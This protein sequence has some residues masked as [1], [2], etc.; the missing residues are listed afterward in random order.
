MKKYLFAL[1]ILVFFSNCNDDNKRNVNPF[2]PDYSFSYPINLTLPSFQPLQSNVNAMYI[3]TQ[4]VGVKGI[5]V[6][7]VSAT[8]YRAWEAACPNQYPSD[9]STMKIV[10]LEAKCDCDNLKYNLFTGVGTAESQYTMKP[11]QVE[12]LN[13]SNIRVFN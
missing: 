4:G 1:L 10:G 5:I 13:E 7:R 11:Y 2:L 6:L 8:D 3:S 12:V 9:C